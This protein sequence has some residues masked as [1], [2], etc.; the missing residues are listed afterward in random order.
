MI[1]LKVIQ[2]VM[3]DQDFNQKLNTCLMVCIELYKV[4]IS[5]LIILFIPQKCDDHVCSYS[6]NFVTE[7]N[8]YTSG[9]VFNFITL[10]TFFVLYIVEV[11]REN[12]LITYLEVNNLK[13]NDNESVGKA[14]QHISL[15]R[16]NKIINIDKIYQFIG[17]TSIIM[18]VSNTVLSGI[19]IYNYYL[20]NQ[21][22]STYI[23]NILFMTTKIYDVYSN[24]TSDE[25][26]FYSAYLKTKV[27]YND[28]DPNKFIETS[29][30]CDNL[31]NDNLNNDICITPLDI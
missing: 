1:S 6:E 3:N 14:L 18:F 24:S 8:L 16:R 5:S 21:T 9:L 27:Q 12:K 30:I 26:I 22:T 19:V 13:P 31:N 2:Y 15:I 10:F 25:N 20:D 23:T 28:I 11:K 7:N 4:I 29:I 17:K